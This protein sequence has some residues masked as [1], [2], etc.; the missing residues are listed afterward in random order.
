MG[1]QV[2]LEFTEASSEQGLGPPGMGRFQLE[3][4]SHGSGGREFQEGLSL[5]R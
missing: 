5:A 4:V 2:S 1:G 3:E